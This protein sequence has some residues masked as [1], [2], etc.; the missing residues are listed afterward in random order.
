MSTTEMEVAAD[1]TEVEVWGDKLQNVR[2]LE[3]CWAEMVPKSRRNRD[4]Y[5]A[6]LREHR[7]NWHRR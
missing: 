3:C 2:C 5:E 6:W 4:G 1:G 7:E